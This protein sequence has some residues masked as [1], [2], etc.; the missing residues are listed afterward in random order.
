[1]SQHVDEPATATPAEH[2]QGAQAAKPQGG[3][4]GARAAEEARRSHAEEHAREIAARFRLQYVNLDNNTAVDYGLVERLP[5]D[6]LV[7]NQ[8]IPLER[9]GERQPVAMADPANF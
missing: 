7:K 1:M 5:V 4:S 2:E 9:R 8:F 3:R 6:F